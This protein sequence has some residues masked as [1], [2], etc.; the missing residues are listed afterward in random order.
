[1]DHILFNRNL[2]DETLSLKLKTEQDIKFL[3]VCLSLNTRIQF[4]PAQIAKAIPNWGMYWYLGMLYG[5]HHPYNE[6]IEANFNLIFEA[7]SIIKEM[8]LDTT[9]AELVAGPWM[10]CSY[11][12][13]N[14]RHDMKISINTAMENWVTSRHMSPGA[15]KKVTEYIAKTNKVEKIVI[16]SEQYT[17]LHAM[18]RC[19]HPELK[20]LK[21]NFEVTLVSDPT[22]YDDLSS[23]DFD[24]IIN[25]KE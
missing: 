1:M 3:Y 17:S 14:D 2:L 6:R 19:N 9:A 24:S 5:F 11:I 7:H 23:K 8:Q 16:L 13:R 25:I 15:T 20:I 22:K 10:L 21:E 4:D 18:Y 12:D